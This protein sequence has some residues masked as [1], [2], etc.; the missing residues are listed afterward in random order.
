[1]R[2]SPLCL[3]TIALAT[4]GLSCSDPVPPTPRGAWSVSFVQKSA[5]D[6][7]QAGH[8]T[9]VGSVTSNTKTAVVTDG[10]N[11]AHVSCTVSDLGNGNFS[12][13]A[14][15]SQADK[16]LNIVISSIAATATETAPAPGGIGYASAN[17]V[18]TYTTDD[19]T[20][21][22]FYFVPNSGEGVAAGKVWVAFKCPAIVADGSTCEIQ[23]GYA[24]FENCS[25]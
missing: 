14:Q 3:L 12:V 25:E 9:L 4:C 6:C 16:F 20:P 11:G 19:M 5:V 24:I 22:N 8:N 17:T 7:K 21:C 23:Q 2:L 18:K 10:T 13:S 1:M 15:E